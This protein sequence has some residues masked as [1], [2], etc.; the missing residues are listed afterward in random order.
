MMAS[1]NVFSRLPSSGQPDA[2][3]DDENDANSGAN[4]GVVNREDG[5]GSA[6][7]V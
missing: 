1:E 2:R 6:L 3:H 4:D 7:H 5:A